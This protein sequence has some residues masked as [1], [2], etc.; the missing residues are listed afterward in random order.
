M[1]NTYESLSEFEAKLGFELPSLYKEILLHPPGCVMGNWSGWGNTE[2]AEQIDLHE[3]ANELLNAIGEKLEQDDFVF[4]MHEGYTFRYM[5]N[6][7][8]NSDPEVWEY[9]EGRPSPHKIGD[10]FTTWFNEFCKAV[11]Q[12]RT[13]K[14]KEMMAYFEQMKTKQ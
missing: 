4:D 3:Y 12:E 7:M 8:S 9:T 11:D 14:E 5:K 10:S 2:I 1:P 6:L 13:R